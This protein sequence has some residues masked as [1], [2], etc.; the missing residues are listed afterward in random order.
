MEI[1]IVTASESRATAN[2]AQTQDDSGTAASRTVDSGPL[3]S[4]GRIETRTAPTT[5]TVPPGIY[6]PLEAPGP[7]SPYNPSS[8]SSP[9]NP[10]STS[11]PSSPISSSSPCRPSSISRPSGTSRAGEA[12]T[13]AGTFATFPGRPN[14]TALTAEESGL[15][16]IDRFCESDETSSG[17]QVTPGPSEH[18]GAP[19]NALT[20]AVAAEARAPSDTNEHVGPVI[21]AATAQGEAEARAALMRAA[22]VGDPVMG[23]LV[24]QH[25]AQQAVRAIR[26]RTLPP[27][28]TAREAEQERPPDLTARLNTWYARLA[29]SNPAADVEMGKS[30][31]ARLIIPGDSEWPTQLDQLGAGRPLALW[32][33]GTADLRFSCLKSVA[34]VGAR[35]ATSYGSH[36]AAEFGVGLSES[37]WTVVSGGAFGVDGAAHKG[38][39]AAGA[40]TVVVLACGVDV[41]YPSSHEALFAAVGQQGVLISECPPGVHPTRAR[42]LIRNRLIA[43]LS[44]GTVVVEAALRSGALNTATHALTLTRHL[45]AVPGPITSSMSAGCHRLLRERKAVCVTS[46][47]DMIELVGVLGDDLTPQTRAPAVPRD[48]L[49]ESTKR[50][51][52]AVPTRGGAGPASIAVAAGVGLDTALSALGGLAAAGYVERSTKG[53][54]L[55]KQ[56][57]AYRRAPDSSTLEPPPAPEPDPAEIP[58]FPEDF[59]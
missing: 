47:E 56:Q 42:F 49:N 44:R 43:A 23:R 34:V 14:G 2:H 48:K 1:S 53:W 19:Q 38:A 7:S 15:S 40:P 17:D 10:F 57:T 51:L 50:V 33:H 59:P 27:E 58:P 21:I 16:K 31:G 13:G 46:P 39:L 28:F 26:S 30:F 6:G 5:S 36:V 22:D 18:A 32:A 52:D 25:G 12:S 55:R 9:S 4:P 37:G 41:C 54:R 24:D 45:G 35:A 20:V 8:P 11:R 29:A 3:H